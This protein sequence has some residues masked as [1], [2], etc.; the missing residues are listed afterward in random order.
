[1]TNRCE[2]ERTRE[3]SRKNRDP[4][5]ELAVKDPR[6]RY[7]P[8]AHVV[9]RGRTWSLVRVQEHAR[10]CTVALAGTRRALSLIVPIDRVLPLTA[11]RRWRQARVGDLAAS[12]LD[13]FL[14]STLLARLGGGPAALALVPWQFA[15]P[16][17]FDEGR[18]M[19]VL[20]ADAV[21][22]GK[23]IQA[24]LAATAIR[25]RNEEARVLVLTPAALRDQWAHEWSS[26]LGIRAW[27][28]DPSSTRRARDELP[29][30]VTPWAANPVVI[31]SIDYLKQPEVLAAAAAAPWDLLILDE[32]HNA[33]PSSDRRV[34]AHALASA[35]SRVLLVTATPH[36]GEDDGFSAL[37]A[38]GARTRD[39]SP[40]VVRR[41]R[42]DVGLP[43]SARLRVIRVP[44]S[45]AERRMHDGLRIYARQVWEER[46]AG[47]PLAMVWL[48]KRAASSPRALERSLAH[49][50]ARL[51]ALAPVPVGEWLPFEDEVD[52]R[53]DRDSRVPEELGAPGLAN[54]DRE[55]KWLTDL[56]TS[57]QAAAAEWR[58]GA[59]LARWMRT[60]REPVILFTE[61]RDSLDAL[62]VALADHAPVTLHGGL[63][64]AAR[65]DALAR[66]IG[67]HVRVL[68]TTDV[69]GE[70][71]NLQAAAHIVISLELPWTPSRLEQR[72]GR[73]D[74]IGQTRPVKA[75]CLVGTSDAERAV[76]RRVAAR[77][78][79]ASAAIGPE[80]EGRHGDLLLLAAALG[81]DVES[82][83]DRAAPL[84]PTVETPGRVPPDVELAARAWIVRRAGRSRG[85]RSSA[86]RAVPGRVPWVRL[87]P[88][89]PGDPWAGAVV[90]VYR[91]VAIGD[92][93]RVLADTLVALRVSLVLAAR[94]WPIPVLLGA[95]A[96]RLVP[97]V[98][99]AADL[100]TGIASARA[101]ARAEIER[102]TQPADTGAPRDSGLQPS[103]FDRR[104][105]TEAAQLKAV[106][107]ALAARRDEHLER[108][109][110][111]LRAE[112]SR[113]V[114]PVAAFVGW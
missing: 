30:G 42:T 25:S 7:A 23:T 67:G 103:L 96:A 81:V 88:R 31:A 24:G 33:S 108:L 5:T 97:E 46:H 94:A 45:P 54:R 9:A 106:R 102:L 28:A 69:A 6:T 40:V 99:R 84:P 61:Y 90:L 8:G 43:D 72:V 89:T 77:V 27:V 53:D 21:G 104:A 37:S 83:G 14:E 110:A 55:I 111:D 49:R 2:I 73:V 10:C 62:V 66:F 52:E 85:S 26:R 58:K 48:M 100:D 105:I 18:A 16:L 76:V 15:V 109:A 113:T 4:T 87:R 17:A 95:L 1:M 68:A 22:L 57:A 20:L 101:R 75:A 59:A 91:A 112:P 47:A 80:L 79:R 44:V 74:R 60:S 32:A 41:G 86:A 64:R 71:L 82:D 29:S 39:D 38:I 107:D 11:A 19:R 35:A 3:D 51:A 36:S 13:A 63:S 70:G 78:R 50:L 93:Q 56:H 34:A 12:V 65:A 114:M 92:R 98:L